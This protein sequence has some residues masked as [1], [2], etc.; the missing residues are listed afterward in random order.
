MTKEQIK[1]L[2]FKSYIKNKL[3]ESRVDLAANKLNRKS[4]KE[5]IRA[6]KKFESK[7]TI[8]VSVPHMPEQNEI[9]I[10]SDLFTG[11]KIVYNIDPA[12]LVGIKLV[13]DDLIYDYNLKNTLENMAKF[14]SQIY[15]Y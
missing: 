9:K 4:L 7:N 5:Y 6:L 14:A 15:E 12:I 11:K 10:L 1:E 13:E 2:V 8:I 3:D